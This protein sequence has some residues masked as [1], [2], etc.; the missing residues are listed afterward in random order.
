M[1][2]I[3]WYLGFN[4]IM[5]APRSR[6]VWVK[7][8]GLPLEFWTLR[9]LKQIG[10]SIGTT[11][12]ID[13]NIIGV[14]DKRI[15]WL[16]VEVEFVGGLPGDVDLLWGNRRHRQRIDFWGI[17]FRCL[18]CHKTGHL[19]EQCPYRSSKVRNAEAVQEYDGT[20]KY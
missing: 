10:D 16:L 2:L 17:P 14:A 4:P 15:A 1:Q 20:R 11:K 12:Y 19:R 8:P 5:E 9:A 13:P 18:I 6:I 3:P 7:L